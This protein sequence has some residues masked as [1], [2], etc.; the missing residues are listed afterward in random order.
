MAPHR[1]TQDPP[2]WR[3][4]LQRG[5]HGSIHGLDVLLGRVGLDAERRNGL[6]APQKRDDAAP[7][8]RPLALGVRAKQAG[9]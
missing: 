2:L 4:G 6:G 5:Q 1:G 7:F 9:R 8:P 3:L